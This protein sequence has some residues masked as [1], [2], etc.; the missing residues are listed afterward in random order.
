MD[1]HHMVQASG[2]LGDSA[3]VDRDG[4]RGGA[5]HCSS[6]DE[7]EGREPQLGVAHASLHGGGHKRWEDGMEESFRPCG[8][9]SVEM[10]GFVPL[11]ILAF[12]QATVLP[13]E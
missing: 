9:V 13:P 3:E 11:E 4:S 12:E 5:P 2:E 1:L 7:D 8:M 10:N 6:D